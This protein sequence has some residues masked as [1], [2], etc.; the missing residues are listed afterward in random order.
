MRLT[1]RLDVGANYP[2]KLRRIAMEAQ[3]AVLADFEEMFRK[4]M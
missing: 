2:Q 3:S 4:L 1:E